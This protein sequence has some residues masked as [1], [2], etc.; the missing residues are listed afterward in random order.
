MKLSFSTRSIALTSLV[1][2]GLALSL[3]G[4]G[5]AFGGSS[6]I[7]GC[8]NKKT[9]VLRVVSKCARDETK[10]SWNVVGPQGPAGAIGA[11]G[12]EGAVGATGP[13]GAV[14]STGPQG[15]TGATGPQGLTGATGPQGLTGATGPQGLT[16]SI[17]TLRTRQVSFV[18][19]ESWRQTNPEPIWWQNDGVPVT[20]FTSSQCPGGTLYYLGVADN[21][22]QMGFSRTAFNCVVSVYA[23]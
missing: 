7:S 20:T 16:G 9:F 17:P 10:I 13:E 6:Q 19:W 22:N 23:P 12:A 11:T 5:G 3:L 4:V 8:I 18:I 21:S 15:L 1:I 2:S 14:G